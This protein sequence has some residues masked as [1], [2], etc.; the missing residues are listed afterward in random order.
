[1]ASLPPID[2]NSSKPAFADTFKLSA[3]K[4]TRISTGLLLG[5]TSMIPFIGHQLS[6]FFD[7]PSLPESTDSPQAALSKHTFT[8]SEG[9]VPTTTKHLISDT[10]EMWSSIKS[11]ALG[12][13]YRG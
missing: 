2:G 7:P 13:F 12:F 6:N 9:R 10:G 3:I 11:R 5:I 1:M 8:E 4:A